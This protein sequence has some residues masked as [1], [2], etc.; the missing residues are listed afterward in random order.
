[1]DR[2][3]ETTVSTT[4][5][6][7]GRT[8]SEDLHILDFIL[9]RTFVF[10]DARIYG[11]PRAHNEN[12]GEWKLARW[13]LHH[14]FRLEDPFPTIVRFK[15]SRQFHS[16]ILLPAWE[17]IRNTDGNGSGSSVDP[18]LLGILSIALH[19]SSSF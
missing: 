15:F 7:A 8:R 2:F 10:E 13:Q 17:Q 14:D 16:R 18:R 3:R 5:S 19:S 6:N 12:S 9:P 11:I 1:M 4:N